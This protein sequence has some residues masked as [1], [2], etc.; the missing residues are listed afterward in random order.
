MCTKPT[1][2]AILQTLPVHYYFKSHCI[3]IPLDQLLCYKSLKY[4]KLKNVY[5]TSITVFSNNK[6]YG[7]KLT[8]YG[9]RNKI[10]GMSK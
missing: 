7:S 2:H 5:I 4:M 3:F 9:I 8:M 6:Y 10:R 1:L